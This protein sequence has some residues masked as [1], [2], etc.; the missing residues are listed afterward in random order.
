MNISISMWNFI[1]YFPLPKGGTSFSFEKGLDS[2]EQ[3]VAEAA[4]ARCGIELWSNWHS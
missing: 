2:L 1:H 4:A 3:V